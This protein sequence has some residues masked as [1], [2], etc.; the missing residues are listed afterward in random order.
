MGND[1]EGKNYARF[2]NDGNIYTIDIARVMPDVPKIEIC[3]VIH[4]ANFFLQ[5]IF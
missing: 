2:V 4:A 5:P 1:K 3:K